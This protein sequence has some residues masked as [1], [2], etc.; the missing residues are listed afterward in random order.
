M[1]VIFIINTIISYVITLS[2]PFLSLAIVFKCFS[3]LNR[4]IRGNRP[5]IVLKNE[6]TGEQI[7][8]I[9]WEN[10][11][12]RSKLSDIVVKDPTVSREHAVLMRRDEGWIIVDTN[13]KL[14]VFVNERKINKR[15]TVYPNDI[16]RI[17]ST[18]LK[19]K[20]YSNLENSRQK[21]ILS[22]SKNK[23]AKKTNFFSLMLL[24]TIFHS[25][26]S[27]SLAISKNDFTIDIWKPVVYFSLISWFFYV[28]SIFVLRRVNFELEILAIFLSG[29]GVIFISEK[30]LKDSYIQIAAFT[31]GIIL[32]LFMTY[33]IGNLDRVMNWRIIITIGAISLLVLNLLVGTVQNGSQNWIIIGP[34]SIQPSEF[35]KIAFIFVG[36]STLD[37]LQTTKNLT[38]FIIFS[39]ICIGALFLMGDFGTACIFFFTFLLISFMRSGDI[40]TIVLTCS[41]AALG[42]FMI[43]KFKP[44][45]ANRFSAWRHVW[46][47]AD[48]LGYQQ[49]RV[50]TYSASGGLFGLGI[51]NGDLKYVFAATNDLVFGMICE[52]LGLII[53]VIIAVIMSGIAMYS[54]VVSMKGRSTF[55]YISSCAASGLLIVQ[56]A[57]NIFGSTDLLPLTGVTLPFVSLGGSSMVATWGMLS[58]IKAADERT[59]SLKGGKF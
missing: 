40:R 29:I 4:N 50:L 35:V 26:M 7:P 16:I 43:L 39:A 12:G 55:Y 51:G 48:S 34:L 32:F 28:F 23:I 10:S 45:V 37:K 25:F 47:Y 42:A 22:F 14:G 52:E 44:Y 6:V 20:K 31:L 8:I 58:F 49:T 59:Y 17:G 9:Y 36:A 18:Y 38:E 2:L 3:S 1:D 56:S 24:I 33:F 15:E 21:S 41:A 27:V 5:L 57:L 53:A 54:W 11:V 46:E 19:L 13:S 30:S